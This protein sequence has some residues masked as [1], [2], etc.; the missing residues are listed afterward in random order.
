MNQRSAK[1]KRR[2]ATLIDVAAGS[3]LLAIILIPSA[4][5]LRENESMHRSMQARETMLFEAEQLI[6]QARIDTA[7]TGA[8][9]SA[10]NRSRPM[11]RDVKLDSSDGPELRGQVTTFRDPTVGTSVPLLTIDCTVW[12]DKN[13]NG[14]LD[15]GEPA[16]S[17]RTQRAQP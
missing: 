15:V 17:L 4:R 16:E 12:Q 6:E 2:G 13:N 5:L 11:L 7:E 8:F 10:L 9:Q 3:M 1:Q 14:R